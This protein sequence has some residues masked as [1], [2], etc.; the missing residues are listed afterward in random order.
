LDANLTVQSANRSFYQTF[1]VTPETT[2]GRPVH[3]LGNRQLD[4]PRLRTLLGE[5]LRER[6]AVSNFEVSHD[7]P[8]LGRRT[9]C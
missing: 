1:H 6:S 3:E 4:V 5:V 2:V 8:E 7:F 9:S